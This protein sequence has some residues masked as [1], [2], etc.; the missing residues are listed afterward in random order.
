MLESVRKSC[1]HVDEP[2]GILDFQH[3]FCA[4]KSGDLEEIKKNENNR[5]E[6]YK[7][8]ASLI[9][10]WMD[11]GTFAQDFLSNHDI[12]KLIDEIKHHIEMR[13]QIKLCSGDYIDLKAYD[14]AMRQLLDNYISAQESEVLMSLNDSSLVELL[15]A[16]GEA[17]AER[18]NKQSQGNKNASSEIIENNVRK[19]IVEKNPTNPKYYEEL[20]FLLDELIQ[21]RKQD[22]IEYTEYLKKII[23]LTNRIQHPEEEQ[24][25]PE[26]IK[27]SSG[28]RALFDNIEE[29]EDFVNSIDSIIKT[30]KPDSWYGEPIKERQL[31]RAIFNMVEEEDKV[32]R[33]FNIIKDHK[34]YR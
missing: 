20:S 22:T 6:Y 5:L 2:K 25:Y 26:S 17:F 21:Q 13:D 24:K 9:R 16:E 7:K 10:A 1:E 23:E 15:A 19:K 11:Y 33:I 29:D 18:L 31:K 12:N 30:N 4:K 14:P 8:V 28:K 34:E 3:Y 32:E 27:K